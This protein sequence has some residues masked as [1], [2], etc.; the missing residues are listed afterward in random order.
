MYPPV[1]DP[2]TQSRAEWTMFEVLASL[3]DEYTVLHGVKLRWRGPK[4]R[5]Q[6]GELDFVVIHPRRGLLVLEV[7]GGTI[8]FDRKIDRW[9]SMNSRGQVFELT[10]PFVQVERSAR[11]LMDLLRRAPLTRDYN[12][13]WNRAVA[14]PEIVVGPTFWGVDVL[15]E[16]VIGSEHLGTIEATI[17]RAYGA[18]HKGDDINRKVLRH[19]L[20]TLKPTDEVE[21]LGLMSEMIGNALTIRRLTEDQVRFL[22]IADDM[23]HAVFRGCAGSG[24][25]MLALEKARRLAMQGDEVLLTC[26]NR[27]LAGW[28]RRNVE[29]WPDAVAEHVT[30]QHYHDLAVTTC[31][32]VGKP[33]DVARRKD[34]AGFWEE[35]LPEL[36]FAAASD[37]PRRFDAIVVDEGQDFDSDWWPALQSLLRDEDTGVFYI[38]LDEQQDLY[39]RVRDLPYPVIPFTL[40]ENLRNS[41]RITD[42]TNV[43]YTDE[44]KPVARGPE[45]REPE[46][47]DVPA[48]K[49]TSGAG[50]DRCSGREAD[51][52]AGFD[53]APAGGAG[54]DS[55]GADHGADAARGDEQRASRRSQDRQFCGI[56]EGISG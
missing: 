28:L 4:S 15:P 38:F 3:P 29:T 45:G 44:L 14:F 32:A 54:R 48:G 24:K 30:V 23:P 5:P 36:F 46:V 26:F 47:I 22:A 8:A 12:L 37:W 34:E 41:R 21:Q 13:R 35:T 18:P 2:S 19:L 6:D 53:D 42:L 33:V 43:Y 11:A 51:A 31:E 27:A 17:E 55:G 50:G 52:G 49:L 9:T 56:L 40:R 16:E 7:K 10:N 20:E 39:G 25:T 1:I